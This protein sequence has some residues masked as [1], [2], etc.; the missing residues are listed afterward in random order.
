M[1]LIIKYSQQ[2]KVEW[3]KIT[4]ASNQTKIATFEFVTYHVLIFNI[5]NEFCQFWKLDVIYDQNLLY[6]PSPQWKQK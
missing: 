6:S 2:T 4:L 1:N 5:E 3:H